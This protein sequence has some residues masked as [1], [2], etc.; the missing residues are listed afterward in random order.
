MHDIVTMKM[1]YSLAELRKNPACLPNSNFVFSI[2]LQKTSMLCIFQNDHINYFLISFLV[3]GR[4]HTLKM[5]ILFKFQGFDD[6]IMP[7]ASESLILINQMAALFPEICWDSFN[8][9]WLPLATIL[10]DFWVCSH[11]DQ[12][13]FLK[14]KLH[15]NK[16]IY[17]KYLD[18]KAK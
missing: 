5:H 14:R 11:I 12:L 15:L 6:I 3:I 1:A 16:K 7:E 8:G 9:Y 2:K 10:I 13:Q 18:S 4:T 17:T